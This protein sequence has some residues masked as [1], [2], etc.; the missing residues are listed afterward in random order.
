[1]TFKAVNWSPNELLAEAK[2]DQMADNATWLYNN[3]PRAIY[4]LP[5]GIRRV[6][7][8]RLAAGRAVITRRKADYAGVSIYFGNFFSMRCEPII[9][10]GVVSIGQTKVFCTINGLGN[11]VQPDH[12]G[13]N[14][15]VQVAAATKK[16]DKIA[17]TKY[18]T[19]E[20]RSY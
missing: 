18:V 5:G 2:T 9:T 16:D 8:V 6:E 10:T 7:G 1:M 12:T 13:F 4:T 19:W 20:G 14:A 17:R 3:T 11:R 15:W